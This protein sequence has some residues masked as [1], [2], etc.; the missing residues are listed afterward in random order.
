[1]GVT[2]FADQ[3]NEQ[4]TKCCATSGLSREV[5]ELGALLGHYAAHSANMGH[6]AAHSAN[7]LSKFRGNLSG[8]SSM[9]R[10][11]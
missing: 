7:N 4:R 2:S 1:M 9:V 6:Y 8:P 5:N 10:I 11:S 3:P